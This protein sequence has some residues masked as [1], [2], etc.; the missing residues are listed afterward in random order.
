MMLSVTFE[1]VCDFLRTDAKEDP[2]LLTAVD[3][4][5]GLVLIC[6][7]V[8]LPAE[9]VPLLPSLGVKNELVQTGKWLF[10]R[11]TSKSESETI[12]RLRRIQMAHCLLVYTAF[13]EALD[14]RL[15]ESLRKAIKHE[16][17][18]Y[19]IGTA[20][21]AADIPFS[22]ALESLLDPKKRDGILD[23]IAPPRFGEHPDELI[24]RHRRIWRD[25]AIGFQEALQTLPQ[26]KQLHGGAQCSF[27]R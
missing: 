12:S 7:Q 15:P 9:I 8:V 13:F 22:V 16:G 6:G 27:I 10:E 21:V 14:T 26:W 2:K 18:H 5:L 17:K 3:R 1:Q 4:M 24:Q 23:E 19:E 20:G 25:M 11:L